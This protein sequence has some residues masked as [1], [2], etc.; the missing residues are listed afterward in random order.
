MGTRLAFYS[1]DVQNPQARMTPP[2]TPYNRDSMNDAPPC[3]WWS[4][5]VLSEEGE[6]EIRR[7][8]DKIKA[9]CQTV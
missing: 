6:A 8:A 2:S 1:L 7:V 5:D 9:E 4:V 3:E